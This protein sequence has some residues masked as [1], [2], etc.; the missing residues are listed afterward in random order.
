MIRTALIVLSLV[1]TVAFPWAYSAGLVFLASLYLPYLGLV[2]GVLYDTLYYPLGAGFP[3]ATLTGLLIALL[4]F[5]ARRF[6]KTHIAD[7]SHV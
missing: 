7:F 3:V 1:G 5:F 6:L 4:A 2:F